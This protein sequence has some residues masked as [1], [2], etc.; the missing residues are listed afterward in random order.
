MRKVSRE[1][2]LIGVMA[3][4]LFFVVLFWRLG[5]PT[6]WDPDEAHY[7]ET[8]QEM[9]ATGDWWAPHYNEQPFYDKPALF[10][11][12]Q[13][14]AM[15][16]IAD[17]EAGARIVPALAALG[18]IALTYWFAATLISGDVA[19]V[20]ALMLGAS[21]GVFALS[22]YAI[23]DTLFTLFTFGAAA[24]LAVAALRDRPRLQW[25]GYLLLACGVMV[26]GPLALVLAALT[27]LV[28]AAAS[29]DLRRRLFGLHWFVGLIL[30]VVVSSPWFVYMYLRFR[31]EF[32]NGYILDENVR[33]FAASR[34]ANQPGF[35]FYFQIL[36]TGLL[37]WTGLLI[38]RIID[39]LRCVWRGERVDHVETML[40]S[41]TLVIVGFFTASTF[42][43]DHYVF[44]AAPS[45]CIL[46]ARAW[47]DVRHHHRQPSTA[48]SRL[49][50]YLIGPFL[51]VVGLGCGY[52]VIARLALP[53]AAIAVPIA[54]TFAGA[55][56]TALANVR[57]ALPPRVPWL[58][59][60][61]LLIT[62]AGIIAFV[63]PALEQRKVV[64]EM[65]EWVAAHARPSDR[66]C[67][68]RM[69]R[70]APAY[71]F[72]VRRHVQ[73]LE[74]AAEAEAFFKQPEPFFCI[75]R[76][77]AY[78]EF[79]AQGTRLHPVLEREGMAVTS[80]RALFR[81][82]QPPARYVVVTKAR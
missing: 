57:G 75:M 7:A 35:W 74:D 39:D 28:L 38:G 70:W 8:S 25:I 9:V 21:P 19:I 55:L 31:Q 78:E 77:N 66:V 80:G 51:V 41:W 67:S 17:P 79:V 6:F 49:G 13:G 54:L 72:Y 40:W 46:C 44:P 22:R 71:R 63:L 32:V 52:F 68:F 81:T 48:W 47:T 2:A 50:L 59:I 26:K 14:H 62:Y 45:L 82:P 15:R 30:I 36:A 10:H 33:L 23:L 43:L 42:K 34:F 11:Q 5:A 24:V 65:A 12:L 16:A 69:N 64:P 56:L 53:R 58:V 1:G 27:M 76:R 61:A 37:P 60:G 4:A 29:A 20:A 73:M 18:L 3:A